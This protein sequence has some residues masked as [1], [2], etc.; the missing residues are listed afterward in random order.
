MGIQNL[1][2]IIRKKCTRESIN[3]IDLKVLSGK[4]IA[5]DIS[6][7]LYRF[8]GDGT[9]LES[10]YYMLSILRYYNI[11][12][13]FVFDGKSPVEKTELLEKRS[14]DKKEAEFKYKQLEAQLQIEKQHSTN[15][16]SNGKQQEIYE[17]MQ[18]FKRRFIRL[19]KKDVIKVKELILAF[20]GIYIEADGEA[21]ELCAKLV[22]KKKAYACMS[23]DMDLF[24]YGCPRVL[25]YLSLL[26][27]TVV[28][29]NLNK[30][31]EEMNI[32]F[33]EFKQI[34]VISGTDYNLSRMSK[35]NL[36]QTFKYFDEYKKDNSLYTDFYDWLINNTNYISN[37]YELYNIY[38]LFTLNNIILKKYKFHEQFKEVNKNK[39]RDLMRPEGFI[40]L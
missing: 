28:L 35:N 19:K 36:Y 3:K 30:I 24:L 15:N 22:C 16:I 1:N 38:N 37:I 8:M 27:E 33:M 29:Y 40:F 39:I 14:K 34:C 2:A 6:I 32:N 21:D 4:T 13:I 31:L 18:Y 17:S 11:F 20:G 23:E 25:R 26:N 12:P 9:L 10:I 5:I 7:Y